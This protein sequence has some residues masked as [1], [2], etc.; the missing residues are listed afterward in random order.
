[1]SGGSWSVLAGHGSACRHEVLPQLRCSMLFPYAVCAS[2]EKYGN[3]S[4]WFVADFY[5]PDKET[6]MSNKKEV[7]DNGEII[8]T[9][10]VQHPKLTGMLIS[11]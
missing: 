2:S 11:V 8:D 4:L 9:F 3:K 10:L 5:Y 6:V 7:F 1:M